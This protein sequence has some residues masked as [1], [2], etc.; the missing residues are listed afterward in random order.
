MPINIRERLAKVFEGVLGY[1]A[2]SKNFSRAI[3][4][5]FSTEA[6]EPQQQTWPPLAR[7]LPPPPKQ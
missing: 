3:H 5:I 7:P 4:D 1:D 6:R 2:T